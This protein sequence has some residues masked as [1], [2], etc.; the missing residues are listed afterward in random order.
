MKKLTIRLGAIL[1]LLALLCV[2]VSAAAELIPGG[3]VIGLCLSEGSL[4]VVEIHKEL[5]KSAQEAGL[6]AG[7]K[8]TAINGVIS[9]VTDNKDGLLDEIKVDGTWLYFDF[10]PGE[11]DL[12]SGSPD[13]NGRLCVI[14]AELD[15]KAL[16]EL[17][18]L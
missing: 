2:P 14:G 3:Q 10:V 7:D 16:T 8:L 17:F 12:R 4:T 6:K 11:S 5:G 9:G 15:E 13:V 18:G 1:L